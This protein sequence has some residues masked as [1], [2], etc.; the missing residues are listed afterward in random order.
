[1][2]NLNMGVAVGKVGY[3]EEDVGIENSK[4]TRILSVHRKIFKIC[5]KTSV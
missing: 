4:C 2:K 1:M 3:S 5:V